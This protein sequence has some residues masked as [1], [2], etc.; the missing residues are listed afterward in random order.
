LQMTLVYLFLETWH[1][2]DIGKVGTLHYEEKLVKL[3]IH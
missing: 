3:R 1:G 2:M